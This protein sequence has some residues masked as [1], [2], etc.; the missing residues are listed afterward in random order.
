MS[1]TNWGLNLPQVRDIVVL[2]RWNPSWSTPGQ[3]AAVRPPATHRIHGVI[4]G[5]ASRG[6]G[7]EASWRRRTS[8]GASEALET[9]HRDRLDRGP[10][11]QGGFGS[12][13]CGLS[14]GYS[15][16][17]CWCR[18][19]TLLECNQVGMCWSQSL[20]AES[21]SSRQ[22]KGTWTRTQTLKIYGDL[23]NL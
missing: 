5:D 4:D 7:A 18:P 23:L 14:W 21:N 2:H 6:V 17:C 8:K 3:A 10:L 16:E 13:S 12:L 22:G 9:R 19:P 20:S 1:V 15:F 11:G